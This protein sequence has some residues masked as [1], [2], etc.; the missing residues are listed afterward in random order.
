MFSQMI[1]LLLFSEE[2]GMECAV[3]LVYHNYSTNAYTMNKQAECLL[4]KKHKN[5]ESK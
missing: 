5:I 2:Y 1:L 4:L 3:Q